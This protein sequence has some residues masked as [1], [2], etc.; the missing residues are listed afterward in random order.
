MLQG[1][2]F[3]TGEEVGLGPLRPRRV[4]LGLGAWLDLAP[5]WLSGADELYDALRADVPWR[6]ERRQMYERV[7]DVPRLTCFYDGHE[8]LPHPVLAEAR[9]ALSAHYRAELGE[10]F[11]TLGMCL[12]RDGADSVAW[13]GDRI[14]RSRDQ[15]T[16]IA[17]ISVGSA[18]DLALRPRDGGPSRRFSVGHGDLA[19]MGGSCQRTWDH[20]IPKATGATGPRIS[21]QYRVDGVR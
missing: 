13:H 2:L 4:T 15:D 18:R 8:P 19:V 9:G 12:Y 1:S 7:V 5:G 16:M 17:I 3:D 10:P 11:V 14:G 21:I 20:A 6:A